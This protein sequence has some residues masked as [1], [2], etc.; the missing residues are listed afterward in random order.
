MDR[1]GHGPE[2]CLEL[3]LDDG[4]A[5][6]PDPPDLL[7]Q[8]RGIRQRLGGELRKIHRLQ[9]PREL[10]ITEAGQQDAPHRGRRSRQLSTQA[11]VDPHDPPRVDTAD[12]HD[13]V[14]IRDCRRTRLT[15]GGGELLQRGPQKLV[16]SPAGPIAMAEAENLGRELEAPAVG[17]GIAE[18][19]ESEKH[20]P[21]GRPAEPGLPG[22]VRQRETGLQRREALQDL[23]AG[24]QGSDE[25]VPPRRALP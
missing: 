7:V 20:S 22:D 6:L 24:R 15:D 11:E 8:H 25:F 18:A 23:Q 4:E 14:T 1:N 17:M 3:L 12:I 5:G 13:I 19:D 9:P 10:L 21:R 16:P 2:P